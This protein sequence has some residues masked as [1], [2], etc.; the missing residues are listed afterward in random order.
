MEGKPAR[1]A[2][3]DESGG[4]SV[5]RA[6]GSIINV[7]VRP[8]RNYPCRHLRAIRGFAWMKL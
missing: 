6:L 8:R 7:K 4:A 5:L 1:G 3:E 2:L